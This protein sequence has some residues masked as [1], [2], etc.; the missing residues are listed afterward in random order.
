MFCPRQ[1]YALAEMTLSGSKG[2]GDAIHF[3]ADGAFK[4]ASFNLFPMSAA[5]ANSY[6][7]AP[8][9]RLVSVIRYWI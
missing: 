8:T 7:S 3:A 6:P 5:T 4:N 9:C 2:P 1:G